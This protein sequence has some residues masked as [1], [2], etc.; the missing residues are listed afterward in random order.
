M[1]LPI[2][3]KRPLAHRTLASALAGG[4]LL[5]AGAAQAQQ[6]P[7]MEDRLRAQLRITTEQLQQAQD[8]LAALK[9][10][11]APAGTAAPSA[12]VEKLKKELERER[13]A[14]KALEGSN[15]QVAQDARTA[16]EKSGTQLAQYRSAYDELLKLARTSEA[17]RQRLATE[18]AGQRTA[19]DQ[20]EAKNAQ[21]YSVGKEILDAYES[22][23][24]GT[25]LGA[26]QPFAA[27][28]RV[29]LDEA[30]QQYGDKLYQGRFDRRSVTAPAAEPAPAAV[31]AATPAHPVQ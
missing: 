20:C 13:E 8:E 25:V 3:R 16:V 1:S 17:E 30:A 9:A 14:R 28:S 29:K 24:L 27:Q 31:P 23:G 21:I 6:A 12:D 22:V 10:A 4:C 15:R 11:R 5:L 2:H 26:R 19:L 18:A 7:S